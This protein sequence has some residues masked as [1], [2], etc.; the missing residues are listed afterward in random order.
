MDI[1]QEGLKKD[2]PVFR[3]GD[4]I[5][6][7]AKVVEGESERIQLFDGVV[8]ARRG[9]GIAETF[10]VRKVSFGVGVERIFPI[11]SPR[12]EK[13]E[14][15]KQGKVRRAKLF[16]LRKRSGKAARV[17]ETAQVDAAPAKAAPQ[18][19]EPQPAA[20]QPPAPE[21]QQAVPAQAASAV[22]S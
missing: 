13:I 16:Y 10:T 17:E 5:R 22:Q 6:V 1:R 9:S 18:Q 15:L 14:V 11:H 20:P 4:T 3:P 21:V 7:H 19:V 2:I 8:I 12:V